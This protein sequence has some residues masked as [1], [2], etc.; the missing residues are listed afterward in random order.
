MKALLDTN[1]I[2]H[3]EASRVIHQDIGYLFNWLDKLKIEKCVHPLT[4]EEINKHRDLDTVKTMNIKIENYNELKTQMPFEGKIIEVSKQVDVDDNDVVDSKILNEVYGGRVDILI[5]EDKK[6]HIKA[7]LLGISEKVFTINAFLEKMTAENPDLVDYKVLAVKK[8]YFG[9]INLKDTFFDSFREDY[10][11]FDNW[12]NRKSNEIS[13]VCFQDNQLSAFLFLKV[14]DENENYSDISPIFSKRKRLKIGT[15]KVTS[16]GYKIGER[17]LKIIFDNAFKQKVD[18]IY[19]TIFDKRPE[20][21]SLIF[22][23]ENWGFQFHGTKGGES[24]YV[25]EFSRDKIAINHEQPKLTFPY[26][27]RESDVYIVPIYPAYH[28]E[29]FPDSILKTESPNDFVEN[30]PH[31][32]ALSKVYI[33]RSKEKDLKSGDLI[34]FYRTGELGNAIH[35]GVVTTVGIVE[36]VVTNINDEADFINLCRRRSVFSDEKLKEHWNYNPYNKPAHLILRPFIVNFLYSYSFPKI[37]NLKWLN[38]NGIIPDIK[39]MPRGFRK[40]SRENLN[41]IIEY[42][43]Q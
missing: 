12:F 34:V 3:R 27:S 43:K 40:I 25:K 1:I 4:V 26:L 16:N 14:E 13:Y 21:K 7:N 28:T 38:E 33:S 29:L 18:E 5:S 37:P 23:L 35:T 32:N 2:I 8:Q 39:D 15:L 31:R 10:V 22:M 41:K 9:E 24:V 30:E 42:S 19:V 17:F 6:I 11:G 36:S 20:Q